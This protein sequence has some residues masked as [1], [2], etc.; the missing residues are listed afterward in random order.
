MNE[1]T[2]KVTFGYF[3]SCCSSQGIVWSLL[4]SP[5]CNSSTWVVLAVWGIK[6]V[7]LWW[8][9]AAI[10][11]S[12]VLKTHVHT[13]LRKGWQSWCWMEDA[14]TLTVWNRDFNNIK[15]TRNAHKVEGENIFLKNPIRISRTVCSRE[16]KWFTAW[17][18]WNGL[19]TALFAVYL[20]LVS[21]SSGTIFL[22]VPVPQRASQ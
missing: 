10:K 12:P 20:L 19:L 15:R 8:T 4:I 21:S 3:W 14:V 6:N 11:D 22:P 17:M 1:Q 2:L 7:S 18:R 5:T 9:D 16:A 13:C